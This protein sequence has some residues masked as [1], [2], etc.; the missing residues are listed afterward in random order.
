MKRHAQLRLPPLSADQALHLVTILEDAIAA[1]WRAHGD[2]MAH[3]TALLG[4][5][6]RQRPDS[7]HVCSLEPDYAPDIDDYDLDD[8]DI[9][10]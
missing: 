8:S 6:F 9:E 2:A 4:T 3:E 7:A 1:I 5:D 10:F